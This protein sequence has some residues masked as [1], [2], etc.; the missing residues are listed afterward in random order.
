MAVVI[1][2]ITAAAVQRYIR[3]PGGLYKDFTSVASPGTLLG[4]TKGDIEFDPGIT[5]HDVEP[6]GARGKIK[7]HRCIDKCEPT[8][9]VGLL[10]ASTTN[11]GAIVPGFNSADETP[12]KVAESLGT[13]TTARSSAPTLIGAGDTDFSTLEIWYGA[14]GT[15]CTLAT[16]M[17]DY[18]VNTTTGV[19]T[20]VAE[21]S[22]GNIADADE[23]TAVYEYDST[24]SGDD[25][26]VFTPGVIATGDYWTNV[27]LVTAL[28]NTT[29]T[30]AYFILQLKNILNAPSGLTIPG[31]GVTEAIFQMNFE[32]FFDA[33]VGTDITNAPFE[34]WIGR[35]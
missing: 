30:N 15:D 29:Y 14:A 20:I 10:E 28:T 26:T 16:I 13:G 9:S 24:S 17:T 25:F 21:G 3:G 35:S 19:V 34:W 33:S 31:D 12:T 2:G 22:G 5:F 8:L 1:N 6:A 7:L 27:T 18:T 23:I 4:E 32:A 11:I